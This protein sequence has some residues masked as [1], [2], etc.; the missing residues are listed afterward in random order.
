MIKFQ[1]SQCGQTVRVADEHA[2]RK[3]KCPH[4][5]A[6]LT[7]PAAGALLFIQGTAQ[8]CRCLLCLQTGQWP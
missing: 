7:I 5:Q 4:C 2:G 8:V 6:L 1:C 3:G